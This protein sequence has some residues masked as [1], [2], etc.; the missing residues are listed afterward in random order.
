MD[1]IFV[2]CLPIEVEASKQEVI[3]SS[4]RPISVLRAMAVMCSAF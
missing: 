4:A 2:G 1:V 3:C